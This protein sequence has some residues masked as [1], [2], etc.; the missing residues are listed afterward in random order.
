M[1]ALPAPSTRT[2]VPPG[3]HVS[4]QGFSLASH[5]SF[6]F[7][8]GPSGA[9]APDLNLL[10]LFKGRLQCCKVR[11]KDKGRRSK[12]EPQEDETEHHLQIVMSERYRLKKAHPHRE[13]AISCPVP[14]SGFISA[15][16]RDWPGGHTAECKMKSSCPL[17]PVP[18]F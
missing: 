2:L 11:V 9:V 5:F 15:A 12:G 14:V 13:E 1:T 6:M 17:C 16:S 7:P 4:P 8:S 10:S 3:E 18:H